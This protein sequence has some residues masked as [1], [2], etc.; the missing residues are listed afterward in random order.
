L[1]GYQDTPTS[2]NFS[3][4]VTDV[5]TALGSLSIYLM[6]VPVGGVLVLS[7]SGTPQ[8]IMTSM[9]PL[10][11]TQADLVGAVYTPG[12]GFSGTGVA[13]FTFAGYDGNSFGRVG[14]VI[15]DVLPLPL[16]RNTTSA[17]YV[18]VPISLSL[19]ASNV[20]E[21]EAWIIQ[22]PAY[23]ALYQTT[24]GRSQSGSALVP[25]DLPIRVTNSS[26]RVVYIST[27]LALGSSV[28]FFNDIVLFSTNLPNV[29]LQSRTHGAASLSV[30]N[31]LSAFSQN[32]TMHPFASVS[33]TF[34]GSS[35]LPGDNAS[36]VLLSLPAVGHLFFV[37]GLQVDLASRIAVGTAVSYRRSLSG[38]AASVSTAPDSFAFQLSARDGLL[39]P[40]AS[41]G[42]STQDAAFDSR[43]T[44][45]LQALYLFGEAEAGDRTATA[46]TDTSA[47]GL[48][49]DLSI[50]TLSSS[51]WLNTSAGLVFAGGVSPTG[52]SPITLQSAGDETAL[53]SSI[54]TASSFSLE[55]WLQFS[56]INAPSGVI[57]GIGTRDPT[58][59][60]MS[61]DVSVTQVHSQF[62]V[63]YGTSQQFWV[64]SVPVDGTAGVVRRHAVL[65][66]NSAT[67]SVYVDSVSQVVFP[68][69]VLAPA[70][71]R[72]LSLV[73]G[74]AISVSN[75][76]ERWFGA[77]YLC[78][79]YNRMLS[80]A[81]VLQNFNAGLRVS[82]PQIQ[83][84]AQTQLVLEYSSLNAL[85][86]SFAGMAFNSTT[87]GDQAVPTNPPTL[88]D[89][90]ISALPVFGSLSVS[91]QG[92]AQKALTQDLL[93]FLFKPF[94]VA[95]AYSTPPGAHFWGRQA[96][97][98]NWIASDGLSF[99]S[100]KGV[101][102]ID[103]MQV[104][105]PPIAVGSGIDGYELTPLRINLAG[106]DQDPNPPTNSPMDTFWLVSLPARGVIYAGFTVGA[107]SPGINVNAPFL[108]GSITLPFRVDASLSL[109]YVS[110][111]TNSVDPVGLDTGTDSFTF[112]SEV[113]G[114]ISSN[115][116]TVT[117][118]VQNHLFAG[119]GSTPSY[120]LSQPNWD[121]TYSEVVLTFVG[122]IKSNA[123]PNSYVNASA[124]VTSFVLLTLPGWLRALCLRV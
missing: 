71:G 93:P 25:A 107:S 99:S 22:L 47:A 18:G 38:S 94:S 110:S 84:M 121:T 43:V 11:V 109:W 24:D 32:V 33:L 59:G 61:Y 66:C 78:A 45:G 82:K 36:F 49:G 46:T 53:Y 87:F 10:L 52:S 21:Y 76:L 26:H 12:L 70:S 86:L 27:A 50:V 124:E 31:R 40:S 2:F 3:I 102:Y 67:C 72:S 69:S 74:E 117:T 122:G 28:C 81:D 75:G 118:A 17:A 63:K 1:M 79:V 105:V 29:V 23:G 120:I 119:D 108:A 62:N 8:T 16:P 51:K 13:N 60:L 42:F 34:Q 92:A 91:I 68:A 85:S 56:Q 39:S 48:G 14:V 65:A 20:E 106:T 19:E 7:L 4:D 15:F 55:M 44:S 98:F 89:F 90:Y 57:F 97:A 112:Q 80:H 104:V 54:T 115:V 116:A 41:I 88:L 77:M 9:M 64:E 6:S 58:S 37:S 101:V 83:P 100:A 5:D 73:I 95:F 113:K 123:G 96:D 30:C 35:K 111:P 103:V 114:T